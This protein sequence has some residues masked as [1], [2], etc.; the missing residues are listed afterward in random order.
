MEN[1]GKAAV[2]TLDSLLNAPLLGA[3]EKETAEAALDAAVNPIVD[4]LPGLDPLIDN[5]PNV[6][7]G[8]NKDATPSDPILPFEDANNVIPVAIDPLTTEPVVD[9]VGEAKNSLIYKN[10]LTSVFGNEIGAF[11]Q[12]VDGEEKEFTLDDIEVDEETF[13]DILKSKIEEIKESATRN[14]ISIEGTSE[15]TQKL[16][17]VEK[18]GGDIRSLLEM[19]QTYSDPLE[20]LDLDNVED[21]KEIILLRGTASGQNERDLKRLIK[22]YE[23]EGILE[24]IAQEAHNSLREAID[25]AMNAELEKSRQIKADAEA[26]F[27]VYKKDLKEKMNQFELKDN[28]KSKLVDLATKLN[29]KGGIDL[30]VRYN[31]AR[32]NPEKASRLALFLYDEDEYIK[33]VTKKEIQ[34]KQLETARKLKI[35]PR[36]HTIVDPGKP[37]PSGKTINISQLK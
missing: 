23:E 26:A 10:A 27:K 11:I 6:E 30:D 1:Q 32:L 29:E 14:K 16:I 12:E 13:A 37:A 15:F 31:E 2:I 24:E 5:I 22:S 28:L 36:A 9:P 25:S 21:Q 18:S 35:I 34:S 20:G 7:E 33:Q 17:E 19:K 4:V 3:E 8:L